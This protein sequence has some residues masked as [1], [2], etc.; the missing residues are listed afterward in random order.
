LAFNGTAGGPQTAIKWKIWKL[1][2]K[3]TLH[4]SHGSSNS[5]VFLVR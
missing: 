4:G 2:I 5:S 1:I 3:F